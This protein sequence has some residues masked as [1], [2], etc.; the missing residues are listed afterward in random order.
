MTKL[1]LKSVATLFFIAFS[2]YQVSAQVP[3]SDLELSEAEKRAQELRRLLEGDPASPT[4][5]ISCQPI[6]TGTK[7]RHEGTG[8]ITTPGR[9]APP[10]PPGEFRPHIFVVCGLSQSVTRVFFVPITDNDKI[11]AS[12]AL[13]VIG[14]A[15][16]SGKYLNIVFDPTDRSGEQIGCRPDLC[17][18]MLAVIMVQGPFPTPTN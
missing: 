7:Q 8:G 6:A 5:T 12:H 13:S 10:L 18:R 2:V 9:P 4:Q 16:L 11:F 17:K 15:H 14:A 1:L 3:T